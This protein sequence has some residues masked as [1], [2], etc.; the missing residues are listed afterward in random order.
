[1][2][3]LYL[4]VTLEVDALPFEHTMHLPCFLT[5][6]P[7][8][9][10][11]RPHFGISTQWLRSVEARPTRRH[12]S[13]VR[14]QSASDSA[15]TAQ[16]VGVL[17]VC[18]GNICRSPA[19]EAV[20]RNSVEARGLSSQ[21]RVDSCGTGGG[22]EYWYLKGVRS[23]HEGEESDSRMKR[24]AAERGI[25]IKSNSRP[26]R[27]SD[28]SQFRYIIAM[29]NSNV[30]AIEEARAHWGTERGDS[31][32]VMLLNYAPD[33]AKHGQ[34]VPDP[35]YGGADGFNNA[36]DLIQDACDGLLDEIVQ[37]AGIAV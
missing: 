32:V 8:L 19:A 1:M 36:L 33:P 35:Y 15:T 31:Q 6:C 7:V 3:L 25:D 20:L 29:D 9:P 27:P 26:L 28:F 13:I 2:E 18:L 10:S 12:A 5:G 4:D 21:I 30:E 11:H 22:R 17:M 14:C 16:P 34:P 24:A 23:F 37:Q